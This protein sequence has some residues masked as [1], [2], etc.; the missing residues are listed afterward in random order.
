MTQIKEVLMDLNPWW[1]GEF[2]VDFKERKLYWELKK[3]LPLPHIIALT[4]LRRVGKTT[5]MHKIVQDY[6]ASGIDPRNVVYFS[7]DELQKSEI[8]QVIQTY[9]ALNDK[10]LRTGKYLVLL[11]EI[12]KLDNWENQLKTV[13]DA[14]GKN[15][16]IIISGSESLFFRKKSRETLAGRMFE[17][18][19]TP[20]SFAEFLDFKEIKLAPV[21]L[22]ERELSK[23]LWEFTKTEGFPEL[24]NVSEKSIIK[25]YV[26]ESIVEKVIYRDLPQLVKIEDPAALET[27]LNI[28]ME[29]PGQLI[30]TASLASELKTSRQTI[31]SYLG[32]LQDC[33]L[34][35]KLYNY[36][37]SRRKV[38]RKL[39]KYYP[40]II[41]PDL[42]FREDDL[43]KSRVFEWLAV[44]QLKPEF[45][46]RDSF[47]NE[48]DI[49]MTKGKENI[50]IEVK[51]GKIDTIGLNVFMKK[52]TLKNGYVISNNEERQIKKEGT[53]ISVIPAHRYFLTKQTEKE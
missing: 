34:L 41:S 3:F 8:R 12:Q 44:S 46:W 35:K 22:Y 2:N 39:K 37:K 51:Y 4:G 50:P 40:T 31:S 47:K 15:V 30:E 23:L 14:F 10:S 24:V 53:T 42:L 1:K 19:V 6:L 27:L 32:Y 48:V 7:F 9:E 38:E 29:E 33:F 49:I 5:L 16:K 45:F 36:S 21:S 26:R 20:L 25:K 13:Y 11:D 43:S 17:F 52:N 18:E 28:L